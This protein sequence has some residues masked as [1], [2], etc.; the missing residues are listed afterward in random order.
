MASHEKEHFCIDMSH[1]NSRGTRVF[2]TVLPTDSHHTS[3]NS[4]PGRLKTQTS[5][6]D[7]E[8]IRNS[9]PSSA[10]I[11]GSLREIHVRAVGEQ[12]LHPD[13][14]KIVIVIA[15]QKETAEEVKASVARREE[16][17]LQAI[18][19]QGVG[20]DQVHVS[21]SLTRL[22][23]LEDNND[24][25]LF[26]FTVQITAYFADLHKCETL[27]NLLV[28]KLDPSTVR[29]IPPEVV[30]LHPQRVAELRR[31]TCLLAVHNAKQKAAEIAKHFG[32]FCSL[33][34]PISIKEDEVEEW[35][36]ADRDEQAGSC[37]ISLSNLVSSH[38]YF[39][40]CR[41]SAVFELRDVSLT[42]AN[43]NHK[44]KS[45]GN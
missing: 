26:R 33:G 35:T 8:N 22:E 12:R 44:S 17:V 25:N 4:Q 42:A 7:A 31:E 41:V 45:N 15:N 39:M 23:P 38:A 24:K 36:A 13:R 1:S 9:T 16:Y 34:P 43:N 30:P 11:K 37:P 10:V 27:S 20:E 14:V 29:V 2:A 5:N 3:A 21:K 32:P 6:E 19:N 28:E 18:K 40:R